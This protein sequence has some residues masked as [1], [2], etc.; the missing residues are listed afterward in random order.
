MVWT[1][2]ERLNYVTPPDARKAGGEGLLGSGAFTDVLDT[3]FLHTL[4]YRTNFTCCLLG[5]GTFSSWCGARRVPQGSATII[6]LMA[7]GGNLLIAGPTIFLV[8]TLDLFQRLP[9]LGDSCNFKDGLLA[10]T[11]IRRHAHLMYNALGV[12]VQCT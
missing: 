5:P 6:T 2:E 11:R 12:M 8:S 4:K 10:V 3:L 7:R 9:R 1:P